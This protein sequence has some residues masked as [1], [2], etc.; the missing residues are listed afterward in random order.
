LGDCI[1]VV[2]TKSCF[3]LGNYKQIKVLKVLANWIALDITRLG[4]K[5]LSIECDVQ[6]NAWLAQGKVEFMLGQGHV[7]KRGVGAVQDCRN[8]TT[9]TNPAGCTLTKF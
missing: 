9:T 7:H 1:R 2:T 8:L 3:L 4:E 5:S 6:N